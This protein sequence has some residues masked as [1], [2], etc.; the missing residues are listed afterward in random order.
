[1]GARALALD[2]SE[3]AT[4]LSAFDATRGYRVVEYWQWDATNDRSVVLEKAR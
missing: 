2:T 1:M 4:T 3:R